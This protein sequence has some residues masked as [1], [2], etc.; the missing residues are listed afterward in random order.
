M[1]G[2]KKKQSVVDDQGQPKVALHK[3]ALQD[4]HID[5]LIGICRGISADHQIVTEEGKFLLKWMQDHREYANQYPFDILYIRLS[6]MLEDD[7]LDPDEQK[8]LL[9][10]IKDFTGESKTDINLPNKSTSLP[11]TMPEPMLFIEGSS[12][13]FTGVFTVG[14]RK[15]C[16]ELVVEQ[17]GQMHKTIK[18]DTDYLVI[19]DIGSDSWVH[20][21]HGR[22]IEKALEN[23]KKG[24][25][26]EI[27]SEHHWIKHL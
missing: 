7:I 22:K 3:D 20:S 24:H 14:T 8:E 4:R 25:K 27:I 15:R 19:G 26:I 12:F 11:L 23:I 10:T 2:L 18:K 6:E 17:G 5:E 21:T 16:E 13:V 1:F 9:E